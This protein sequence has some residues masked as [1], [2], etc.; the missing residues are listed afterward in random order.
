MFF[1]EGEYPWTN[2]K[3]KKRWIKDRKQGFEI[4]PNCTIIGLIQSFMFGYVLMPELLK[5]QVQKYS[6]L[7]FFDLNIKTY[8]T[9]FQ[10][11]WNYT[12]SYSLNHEH[13]GFHHPLQLK[14]SSI[15]LGSRQLMNHEGSCQNPILHQKTMS[16][17]KSQSILHQSHHL[18]ELYPAK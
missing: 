9:C 7:F 3:Y 11:D 8:L 1:L 2:S 5:K 16:K 14:L 4:P 6:D 17:Y 15:N 10:M 18:L 12:M 13:F